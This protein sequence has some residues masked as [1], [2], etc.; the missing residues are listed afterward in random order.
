MECTATATTTAA[1]LERSPP[2]TPPTPPSLEQDYD[3]IVLKLRPF[4]M[5]ASV[6]RNPAN[7]DAEM[8]LQ[9]IDELML[10][11]EEQLEE[12]LDHLYSLN[13]IQSFYATKR[14]R[15]E[16][17]KLSLEVSSGA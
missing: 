11:A 1:A 9:T 8:R 10:H 15:A 16:G 5:L 6:L 4:K 17:L 3:L 12:R 7:P 13:D 14:T 2:P